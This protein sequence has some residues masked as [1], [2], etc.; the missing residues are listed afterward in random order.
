MYDPS[1]SYLYSLFL[2]DYFSPVSVGILDEIDTHLRILK[3]DASHLLVPRVS[4][5][6]IVGHECQM[7]LILSELI[8]LRMVEKTCELELMNCR[9]VLHE[10]E[11]EL[12]RRIVFY[13]GYV[14]V[15]SILIEFY[16][17]VDIRNIDVVVSKRKSHS[18]PTSLLLLDV[19]QKTAVRV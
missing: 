15:Q 3:A 12:A 17:S 4:R 10:D 18:I 7:A 11:P 1:P 6:H 2:R 8:R 9:T 5:F 16:R 19:C 13:A 14:K